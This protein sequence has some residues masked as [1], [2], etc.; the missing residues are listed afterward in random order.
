MKIGVDWAKLLSHNFKT[1]T[2]YTWATE[3]YF[4]KYYKFCLYKFLPYTNEIYKYEHN[5]IK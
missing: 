2:H 3:L 4:I 1:H 5:K